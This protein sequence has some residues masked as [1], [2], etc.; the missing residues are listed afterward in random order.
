M[1]PQSKLAKAY[2][3]AIEVRRLEAEYTAAAAD[4]RTA[5]GAAALAVVR[6]R[7]T[8]ANADLQATRTAAAKAAFALGASDQTRLAAMLKNTE[9]R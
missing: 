4:I 1:I 3:L 8:A 5:V 7:L 6:D 9:T 2:H